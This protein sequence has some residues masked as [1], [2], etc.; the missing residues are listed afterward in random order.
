[1]TLILRNNPGFNYASS[2]RPKK[3]VAARLM[4]DVGIA[5]VATILANL[6]WNTIPAQ[7]P[8]IALQAPAQTITAKAV[9]PTPEELQSAAQF[10]QM[11]LAKVSPLKPESDLAPP[12]MPLNLLP[13]TLTP[14]AKPNFDKAKIAEVL[15]V[16]RAAPL[17][18]PAPVAATQI[19]ALYYAPQANLDLAPQD[20]PDAVKPS[21]F[22]RMVSAVPGTD[23][24]GNAVS[25]TVGFVGGLLPRF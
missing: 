20:E 17:A 5:V 7:Q 16:K 24:V 23:T 19:P 18:A 9:A 4:R 25:K 11:A 14:V 8:K 6:I 15:K 21:L 1:M 12:A 10:E 2:A 3:D 13:A 22:K